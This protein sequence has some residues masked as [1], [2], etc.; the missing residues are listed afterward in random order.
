[1]EGEQTGVSEWPHRPFLLIDPSPPLTA[2]F[3]WGVVDMVP[4]TD[5]PDIRNKSAIHSH[6]GSCMVIPREEDRVRLY[7]QLADVDV[8]D[9]VTGRVDKERM[10]P[11]KLLE[12]GFVCVLLAMCPRTSLLS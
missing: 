1:M 4:T 8:R 11:D 10:G 2:D 6:N 5:F 9:P 3:V 7:I 12:V